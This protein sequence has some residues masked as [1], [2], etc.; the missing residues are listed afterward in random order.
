[1][2]ET[3][4]KRLS[5]ENW[6]EGDPILDP[7][8]WISPEGVMYQPTGDDRAEEL[9]FPQLSEKVPPQIYRLF[10]VARGA[11]LYGFFFY[12]L[13]TLG[14][15]QLYRVAEAAVLHKCIEVKAPQKIREG[16]FAKQLKHLQE[17]GI[18]PESETF[19]WEATRDL[20]NMSSHANDQTI[21]LPRNAVAT[22]T[23]TAEQI[24]SLFP[25]AKVEAGS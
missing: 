23:I 8:M 15:E 4:F 17:A 7:F 5:V 19:R 20:R 6:R 2:I 13:Y 11:L 14:V 9:L 1:M 3:G 16:I 25:G 12:P 18:I 21:L 22:L 10:E 24:N